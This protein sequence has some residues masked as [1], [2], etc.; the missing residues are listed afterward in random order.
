M[1]SADLV[2]GLVGM[3][4]GTNLQQVLTDAISS[5]ALVEGGALTEATDPRAA[6]PRS[7]GVRG[8]Y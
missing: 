7:G 5:V 2:A 1:S 4:V 8:P 3:P 6:D